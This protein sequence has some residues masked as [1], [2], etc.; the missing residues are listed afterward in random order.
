MFSIIFLVVPRHVLNHLNF[1]PQSLQFFYLCISFLRRTNA[2]L[3]T[4]SNLLKKKITQFEIIWTG[5]LTISTSRPRFKPSLK[6]SRN[7]S[8]IT[9]GFATI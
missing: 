6:T 7:S 9:S 4:T 3:G 2:T 1:Q 5:T 8:L